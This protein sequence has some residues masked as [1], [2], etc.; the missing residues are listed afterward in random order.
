[1][2]WFRRANF[3]ETSPRRRW[4]RAVDERAGRVGFAVEF[5]R[6]L[7]FKNISRDFLSKSLFNR[8]R[9]IMKRPR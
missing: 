1:M 2:S 5:G 7:A 9:P 3:L 6:C 4:H 8:N